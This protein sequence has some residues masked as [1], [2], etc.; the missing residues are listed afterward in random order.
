MLS[1]A[2]ERKLRRLNHKLRIYCGDNDR[3]AAGIFVVSPSGEYTEICG[4]D[5]NYV[6]EYV[7]YDETGRIRKSGWR[8]TLKILINKGLIKK[9]EAQ[10]EFSSH[11]DGRAPSKPQ[12]RQDTGLQ[13]LKS[14]GI[15]ILESGSY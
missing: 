7:Q 12:I 11:L 14:M 10:R 2:F 15:E 5:K 8:R 1:G 4:A 9:E 6:P 3:F 13:K